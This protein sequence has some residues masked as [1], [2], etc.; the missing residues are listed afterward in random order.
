[1]TAT[2]EKGEFNS[3]QSIH[4][5]IF[6]IWKTFVFCF[7]SSFS[8]LYSCRIIFFDLGKKYCQS[9]S[10]E[11][12]S[13]VSLKE[14]SLYFYYTF[15]VDILLFK[16]KGKIASVYDNISIR[17]IINFSTLLCF[18]HKFS[19]FLVSTDKFM[20]INKVYVCVY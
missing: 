8:D 19:S 15:I 1:M 20:K 5:M 17:K 12:I 3:L 9:P 18:R 4:N 7:P 14:T 16:M 11:P 6:L 10:I 13:R 2:N